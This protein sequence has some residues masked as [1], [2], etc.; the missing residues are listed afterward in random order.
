MATI[1]ICQTITERTKR[2]ETKKKGKK[3]LAT[4]YSLLS[5][6]IMVAAAKARMK[7]QRKHKIKN[8]REKKRRKATA[9]M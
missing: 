8:D 7:S 3:Q 4:V 5:Y 9:R 6:T 2:N 1:P